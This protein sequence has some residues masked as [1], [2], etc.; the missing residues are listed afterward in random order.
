MVR[1]VCNFLL[2]VYFYC[3]F[4]FP[5]FRF[6]STNYV[7]LFSFL[8]SRFVKVFLLIASFDDCVVGTETWNLCY[9]YQRSSVVDQ[10]RFPPHEPPKIYFPHTNIESQWRSWFLQCDYIVKSNNFE[11]D[12]INNLWMMLG[13]TLTSVTAIGENYIHHFD[14]RAMRFWD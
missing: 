12:E 6:L 8:F 14:E 4:Y 13:M 9:F 7:Q 1:R 3:C 2:F 11:I 5:S 10:Y